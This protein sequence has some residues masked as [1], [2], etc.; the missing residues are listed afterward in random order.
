MQRLVLVSVLLLF[1]VAATYT[2]V[3]ASPENTNSSSQAN[4][5]CDIIVDEETG[6]IIVDCDK[7]DHN[8]SPTLTSYK[9]RLGVSSPS[10]ATYTVDVRSTDNQGSGGERSSGDLISKI[11]SVIEERTNIRRIVPVAIILTVSFL[12]GLLLPSKY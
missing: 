3:A 5:V 1:L 9:E 8:S 12:I 4:D 10:Q 2:V 7:H 11:V 6:Q